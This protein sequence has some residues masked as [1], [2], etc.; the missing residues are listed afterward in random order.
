MVL[1]WLTGRRGKPASPAEVV[2][3][4][5]AGCHLCDDARAVLEA[6]G[7]RHP[8]TLRVVDVD[9]D[10]E[11]AA[12]YGLEI[13]VVVIDGKLRFRGRVNAALLERLLRKR[14]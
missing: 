6:A 5:R 14:R 13:P 4:T 12:R 11:L 7:Q 3:Y 2:L 10:P 8:L 9:A 1:E